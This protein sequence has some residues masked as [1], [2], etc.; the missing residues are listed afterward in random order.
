[1]ENLSKV[2][3]LIYKHFS[4]L[5]VSRN[6]LDIHS[7]KI[8]TPV[9]DAIKLFSIHT[10]PLGNIEINFSNVSRLITHLHTSLIRINHIGFCYKVD[11]IGDERNRLSA[12][13]AHTKFHLY[14]EPSNDTSAWLFVGDTSDWQSAMLEF[15]PV[16][17]TNDPY[18]DYWL[19]HIQ[20]D[21]DTTLPANEIEK[22]VTEVYGTS[23]KLYPITIDGIIYIM[24]LP[25][26]RVDGVNIFLDIATNA[27][28]VKYHRQNILKQII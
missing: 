19:P 9:G 26:G 22:V 17:K 11:S 2:L 12:L 8:I 15:L 6:I 23:I 3:L 1:M 18:G 28:N 4:T 5:A 10:S 21:I 7:D 27:R 16:E 25:L 14:E 24:R 13:V 20:I